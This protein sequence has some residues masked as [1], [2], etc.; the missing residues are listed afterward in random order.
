MIKQEF[1]VATLPPAGGFLIDE[2][3]EGNVY[4]TG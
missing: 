1:I 2:I 3:K 4:D